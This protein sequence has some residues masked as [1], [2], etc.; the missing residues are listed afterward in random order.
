MRVN[1]G[2]KLAIWML[3]CPCLGGFGMAS[4]LFIAGEPSHGKGKHDYPQGCELLADSLNRIGLGLQAD[5]SLGWPEDWDLTAYDSIV[6]YSDGLDD[7]V[8]IGHTE[9]LSSA[10]ESGSGLAVLHFATEPHAGTELASFLDSYLGG[11]FDKDLAVNP[12][13]TLQ[14]PI[15]TDHEITNGVKLGPIEDEWYFHLKFA[16]GIRPVLKG[17]PGLDVLGVDGPRSG[18]PSVRQALMNGIPQVLGWTY[19]P[20]PGQRAF[21]FTGGHYHYNWSDAGFRKLIV[22]GILW[23]T[24]VAIPPTGFDTDVEVQPKYETIDEAI[25]RGDEDDVKRH[26]A[27]EPSRIQK[28]KHP[29]LTPLH[30]AIL[31]QREAIAAMLIEAGADLNVADTSLRTPLHLAVERDL[32]ATVTLLLDAGA[33]PHLRDKAGWTPLHHA[34]AK[35]QLEVAANLIK[36]GAGPMTLS[37]RGGTALHE[38]AASG[39][40]A[41]VRLLLD[42]GV[43]PSVVSK[44]GD[45]ALSVARGA[46]NTD[47]IAILEKT[48]K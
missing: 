16:D 17:L 6:I 13:W 18:N 41:M 44:N 28:G 26:I 48:G 4:I 33:D 19:E 29:S 46:G 9:E 7:H 47:A 11:R 34:A 1:N 20:S 2:L 23:T 5:V 10:V 3:I 31:R 21:G 8:A 36:G 24:G 35:D 27:S 32:P 14:S 12:I 43:D 42:N 40:A 22:N 30:Q 37:E 15:L 38:A 25:A 45:T 39:S